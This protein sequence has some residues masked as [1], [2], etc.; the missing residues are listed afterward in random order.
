VVKHRRFD[1]LADEVTE[2]EV[3][4]FDGGTAGAP[5]GGGKP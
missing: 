5:R 3:R 1:L 2:E 4:Y